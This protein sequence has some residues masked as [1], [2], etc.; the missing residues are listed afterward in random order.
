MNIYEPICAPELKNVL[1][2][3]QEFFNSRYGKIFYD[4]TG[5]GYPLLLV[6]GINAGSSNFEWRNNY[7]ELSKYFTVYAPDLPGF[8]K[9]EKQPIQYTAPIYTYDIHQFIRHV[10]KQPVC[11]VARH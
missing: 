9:S 3:N 5:K 11:I 7:L 10:I 1:D 6:H 8:G 4:M 2:N